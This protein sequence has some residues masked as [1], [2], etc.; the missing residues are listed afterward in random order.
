M[1]TGLPTTYP[2]TIPSVTGDE[3]ACRIDVSSRT[4]PAFASAKIGTIRI[5]RPRVEDLLQPLV[6]GDRRAEPLLR[7]PRQLRRRLLAEG[8]EALGR[9]LELRPRRRVGER[10]QPEHEPDDDRIDAGLQDR[11][12]HGGADDEAQDPVADPCGACDEEGREDRD[13]DD[14]RRGAMSSE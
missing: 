3:S 8:A 9:A 1:P 14:Q 11:D 7:D 10:E 4:T 13:A 12:P 2:T 6:R 5:A